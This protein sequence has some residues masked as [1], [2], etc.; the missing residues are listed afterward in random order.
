MYCIWVEVYLTICEFMPCCL[1]RFIKKMNYDGIFIVR[2]IDR[3]FPKWSI[4]NIT[5]KVGRKKTWNI[6]GSPRE[7]ISFWLSVNGIHRYVFKVFF[8]YIINLFVPR[9]LA[10]QRRTLWVFYRA[11]FHSVISQA[12][13]LNKYCQSLQA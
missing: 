9:F 5:R 10:L 2:T 8:L 13:K 4:S 1:T 12:I 3:W 6:N 7:W 11:P